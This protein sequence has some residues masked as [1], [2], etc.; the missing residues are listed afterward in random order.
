MHFHIYSI[1]TFQIKSQKMKN[2]KPAQA[3]FFSIRCGSSLSLP[4][5]GWCALWKCDGI[6][7]SFWKLRSMSSSSSKWPLFA[8]NLLFMD[9]FNNSFF[10]LSFYFAAS[11]IQ[12]ELNT[13]T[14]L[15]LFFIL[16]RM[17]ILLADGHALHGVKK[18]QGLCIKW[19][20]RNCFITK[21]TRLC[22]PL[23]T[24]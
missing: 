22:L 17:L 11:W 9:Y 24:V 19:I 12:F 23:F 15:L 16:F 7:V 2:L 18:F 21:F 14:K 10:Y 4:A 8:L 3:N 13:S 20:S 1:F 5:G 6:Q